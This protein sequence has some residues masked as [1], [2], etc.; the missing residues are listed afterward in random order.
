MAENGFTK[1][2]FKIIYSINCYIKHKPSEHHRNLC[3]HNVEEILN[4]F[5]PK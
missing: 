1:D 2:Q 4:S 3:R 5:N